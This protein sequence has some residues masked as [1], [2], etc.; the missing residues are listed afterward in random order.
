M[1]KATGESRN[2]E[3]AKASANAAKCDEMYRASEAWRKRSRL[4]LIEP[5]VYRY[6]R[7]EAGMTANRRLW[8]KI[9]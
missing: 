1:K 7:N 9:G 8:L 5:V 2:E 3:S 4:A 6:P